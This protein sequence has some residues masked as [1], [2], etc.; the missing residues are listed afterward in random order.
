MEAILLRLVIEAIALLALPVAVLGIP[1]R[2]RGRIRLR[3]VETPLATTLLLGTALTALTF[4][5][6]FALTFPLA[7]GQTLTQREECV[8]N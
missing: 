8:V 1:V 3:V 4:A 5:F 2:R 6:A 7:G